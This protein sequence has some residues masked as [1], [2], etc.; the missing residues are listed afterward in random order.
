MELCTSKPYRSLDTRKPLQCLACGK[1]TSILCPYGDRMEGLINYSKGI[2][3]PSCL[4]CDI[5]GKGV[6]HYTPNAN[7]PNVKI[8]RYVFPENMKHYGCY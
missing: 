2:Y 6:I 1:E 4:P 7:Y 8:L 5:C 3:H